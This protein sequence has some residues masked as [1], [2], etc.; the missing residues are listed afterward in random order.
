MIAQ[1]DQQLKKLVYFRAKNTK[2]WVKTSFAHGAS[3]ITEYLKIHKL[4]QYLDQLGFN[5]VEY[6]CTT[7]IG[8]SEPLK[9][10]VQN[11]II[12]N[13]LVIAEILSCNRNFEERIYNLV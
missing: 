8:N 4:D 6:G 9:P 13:K 11:A 2:P 3:V 7:C 5:L 12:A 10:E 1:L